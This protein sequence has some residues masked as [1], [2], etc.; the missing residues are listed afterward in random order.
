MVLADYFRTYF[1][2]NMNLNIGP[3][4]ED[5]CQILMN[6]D[7]PGNVRE[8]RNVIESA[9]AFAENDCITMG[10]IPAYITSKMGLRKHSQEFG[11][12]NGLSLAE[13]TELMEKAII[14]S[15]YS[16]NGESLTESA[17]ELGISKQLLRYKMMK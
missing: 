1:N 4:D 5:I 8:L 11:L 17:R 7:W 16:R 15:V 6:Y 13:K 10:D 14:D 12:G 2:R 9:F 3:F